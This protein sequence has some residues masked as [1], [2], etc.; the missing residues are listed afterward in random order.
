MKELWP[1]RFLP[2]VGMTIQWGESRHLEIPPKEKFRHNRNMT[3][4]GAPYQLYCTFYLSSSF[5]LKQ[6]KQK[7]KAS[8]N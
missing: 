3:I 8:D 1:G 4:K 7:F 5:A 2:A 6:K